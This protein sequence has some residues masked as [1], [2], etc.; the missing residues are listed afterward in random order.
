MR[1]ERNAC[2]KRKTG[3][4]FGGRHAGGRPG[5]KRVCQKQSTRA[6]WRAR[7][8]P[9]AGARLA[10]WKGER[11]GRAG[12]GQ[13]RGART[14]AA[15]PELRCA[16]HLR[17]QPR[18]PAPCENPRGSMGGGMPC[19]QGPGWGKEGDVLA[20]QPNR[21]TGRPAA[22]R[23]RVTPGAAA[24]APLAHACYLMRK[25]AEHQHYATS[26]ATVRRTAAVALIAAH[27][28][29]ALRALRPAPSRSR[30]A[31]WASPRG[32]PTG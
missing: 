22:A 21:T 10:I 3:C 12:R 24:R 13:G 25:G 16:R 31:R 8:P 26:L 7:P 18:M 27:R 11:G 29:P 28:A 6:R 19:P 17:Y 30:R 5:A 1:A 14:A 2:R 15:V 32:G 20:A 4:A 9:P 23:P